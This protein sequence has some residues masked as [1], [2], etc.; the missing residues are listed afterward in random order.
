[1]AREFFYVDR[2]RDNSPTEIQR[3]WDDLN[4]ILLVLAR[5]VPTGGTTA[6]IIASELVTAVTQ[7][8]RGGFQRSRFKY[9]DT[10]E[11]YL[12]PG[13]Y[14]HKGTTDQTVYWDSEL[15]FKFG[16]GG[17]NGNSHDLA[18]SDWFYLCIDNEAVVAADTNVL[19]AREFVAVVT[20]P[21]WDDNKYGWY[22]GNDVC[23][24]G[25]RTTGGSAV[26]H[27][28]H[29]GS[30]LIIYGTGLAEN[31]ADT[32]LGSAGWVTFSYTAPSFCKRVLMRI[33]YNYID[34]SGVLAA[35]TGG[36]PDPGD[37]RYVGRVGTGVTASL[38][39]TPFDLNSSHEMQLKGAANNKVAT[40][41]Q[42]YY[43]PRG[44]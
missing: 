22:I 3:A 7:A 32:A 33:R 31:E 35:R 16:S 34:A 13:T 11:I 9:K 18:A 36:S 37:G 20:E 2:P 29:D 25:I 26:Q 39:L 30:R 12:G 5:N 1:M 10:D 44:M 21:T 43:L 24:V 6:E 28:T 41:T 14:L 42:G 40:A 27:F 4:Q 8:T 15:T 38:V 17:T 19:T 23:I